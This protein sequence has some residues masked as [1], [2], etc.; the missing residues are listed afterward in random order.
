MEEDEAAKGGEELDGHD[1]HT[2]H[3]HCVAYGDKVFH[4][5]MA[6]CDGKAYHDKAFH[7]GEQAHVDGKVHDDKAYHDGKVC[8]G[9]HV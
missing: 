7:D 5:D 4:D 9:V 1:P 2:R 8:G 6:F 3:G